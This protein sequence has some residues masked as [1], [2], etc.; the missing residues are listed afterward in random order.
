MLS[1][2]LTLL[3]RDVAL[4]GHRSIIGVQANL[5]MWQHGYEL[6]ERAR[7]VLQKGEAPVQNLPALLSSLGVHVAFVPLSSKDIHG[8]SIWEP[9]AV[10]ILLINSKAFVKA[11]PGALRA[12]L[13]HELCHLLH[14]AGERSLTTIVSWGQEGS[15]NYNEALE[16]R[17]RAFAPAFLAPPS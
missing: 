9:G 10:P 5:F 11:H 4:A 1:H 15:G 2:L 14:D 3:G 17:A 6:G 12:T 8:A 16:A 7:R 13:A